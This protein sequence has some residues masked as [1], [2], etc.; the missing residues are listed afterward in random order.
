LYGTNRHPDDWVDPEVFMPER[1][2]GWQQTPFNFVPQ[3]GGSYEFGHR[4]AGEFIT[5]VVIRETLNL[6]VNDITFEFTPQ[7]SGVE[8][9]DI[10]FEVPSQEFG[11]E[12]NDIPAVANDK[13]RI[14]NF[15]L[16]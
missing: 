13:M 6:L 7:D 2:D 8:C 16:K 15:M 11:F 14:E 12:F 5:I 1:F 3:G 4:C 10:T 9:N